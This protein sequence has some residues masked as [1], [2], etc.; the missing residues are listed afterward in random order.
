MR[1]A[2]VTVPEHEVPTAAVMVCR[3][4]TYSDEYGMN[5]LIV[6]ERVQTV[7]NNMGVGV[8]DYVQAADIVGLPQYEDECDRVWAFYRIANE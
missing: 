4:M 7:Y 5:P 2:Q 6:E 1:V 8:A 3:L